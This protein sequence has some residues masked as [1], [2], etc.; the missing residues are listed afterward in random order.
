[1]RLCSN[2]LSIIFFH[3]FSIV[4]GLVSWC[5]APFNRYMILIFCG[6]L[7]QCGV[8][9]YSVVLPVIDYH[10]NIV[11]HDIDIVLLQCGVWSYSVVWCSL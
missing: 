2:Y 7:L 8:C 1:M 11:L 5:G 3:I 9:Y 4:S 10:F 6:V